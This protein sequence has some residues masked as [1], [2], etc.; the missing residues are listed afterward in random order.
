MDETLWHKFDQH[1][2]LKAQLLAT[3]N[4]ELVEVRFDIFH[5][6]SVI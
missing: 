4:A 1:P 6:V 5:T 3:G 2:D